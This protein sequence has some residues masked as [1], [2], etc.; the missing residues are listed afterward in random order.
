MPTTLRVLASFDEKNEAFFS[1][2]AEDFSPKKHE[3]KWLKNEVEITNKNSEIVTPPVERK[4][5]NGTRYSAAS[6][7]TVAS[8]EL[9][10][11][12]T[13]TC[14][15]KGKD[16]KGDAFTN[17]SVSYTGSNPNPNPGPCPTRE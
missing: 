7:L 9:V 6:F 1:C 2:F 12:T 5:V 14:E 4:T 10:F 15:F 3:I 11:G 16:A 17:S 8:D 13:F